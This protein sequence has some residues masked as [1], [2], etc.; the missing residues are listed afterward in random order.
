MSRKENGKKKRTP[1]TRVMNLALD[2][3]DQREDK[4]SEFANSCPKSG[5][6]DQN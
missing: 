1:K 5:I 4:T 2:A 3:F 6:S